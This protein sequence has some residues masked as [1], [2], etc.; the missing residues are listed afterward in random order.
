METTLYSTFLDDKEIAYQIY[1][2]QKK[3][4]GN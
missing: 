3:K 1:E 4:P 2:M